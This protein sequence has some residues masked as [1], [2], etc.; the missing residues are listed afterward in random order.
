MRVKLS[1]LAIATAVAIL[2]AG[3]APASASAQRRLQDLGPNVV[4]FSPSMS[5]AS[6]QARLDSISAQQVPNQFGSQRYAILFEPGTYGSA[7]DPLVFQV[8]YYTQ[9]AGLGAKPGDVVINGAI[10][11]FNQCVNG[12]CDGT[13]NFWR[14][15]SNLTLNVN[16]PARPRTMRPTRATRTAPGA[17]TRPSSGRSPRRRRCGA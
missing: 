12:A 2:A 15:V 9:V 8:G 4:V 13:N 7:T 14:S 1:C 5:Q 16:L 10:D 3:V 6:I 17:R 11:V